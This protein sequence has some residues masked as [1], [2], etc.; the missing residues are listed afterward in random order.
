MSGCT[1]VK[2]VDNKCPYGVL[3]N[4]LSVLKNEKMILKYQIINEFKIT[5]SF[6]KS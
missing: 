3:V 2:D 6:Q 1:F 4:T 5:T